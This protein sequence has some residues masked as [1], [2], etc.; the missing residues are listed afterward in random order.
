[1]L[2][3]MQ[4]FQMKNARSEKVKNVCQGIQKAFRDVKMFAVPHPGESV[5]SA[6]ANLAFGGKQVFEKKFILQFKLVIE[7]NI[8]ALSG[9]QKGNSCHKHAKCLNSNEVILI[10][11]TELQQPNFQPN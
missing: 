1:M 6:S 5:V 4:T 11:L 9:L 2:I 8:L 7:K 3:V 10:F